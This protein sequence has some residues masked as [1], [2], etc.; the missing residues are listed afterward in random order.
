METQKK[1]Q[2]SCLEYLTDEEPVFYDAI[3]PYL[4]KDYFVKKKRNIWDLVHAVVYLWWGVWMVYVFSFILIN[5]ELRMYETN[6]WILWPEL[7]AC[8]LLVVFGVVHLVR[9]W[10][11]I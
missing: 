1:L 5:G 4:D 10:K 8:F 2:R 3:E 6:L 9:K 11:S 7:V